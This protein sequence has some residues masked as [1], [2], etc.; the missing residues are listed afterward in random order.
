MKLKRT[1]HIALLALALAVGSAASADE[2]FVKLDISRGEARMP[3]YVIS[4]D[5]ATATLVLLP[6]GDGG[7]GGRE[8]GKPG[9]TNFLSRSRD[10]FAAEGFN[11]IVIYRPSDLSGL[12]YGYRISK[13]HIAEIGKAIAYAQAEFHKPVWLV[14][15]SRGTVSATAAAI[16][17]GDAVQGLVLTSS[18]TG[19]KHVVGSVPSQDLDRLKIPTLVVHHKNDACKV[20]VPYAA[21]RIVSDLKAGPFKK[22]VLV[23]GGSDPS[24]DPCGGQHWHGFP[25]YEKETVKI[26][27]AWV[28]SPTN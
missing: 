11:V 27:T 14:G 9:S 22:F 2:K 16:A 17:L 13:E 24:G 5:Q 25:N 15:T 18:V 26:I 19:G 10:L 7:V 6:G 20:C 8:N 23:D 4:N 3:M 12:D 21:S 1:I 28:K